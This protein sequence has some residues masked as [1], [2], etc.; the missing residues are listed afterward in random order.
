[1]NQTGYKNL[2]S[3]ISIGY[4]NGFY[5]R[6]RVDKALLKEFNKGLI[7]LTKIEVEKFSSKPHFLYLAIDW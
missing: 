1:M 5:Y 2:L 4:L 7:Y 3:L 6:P